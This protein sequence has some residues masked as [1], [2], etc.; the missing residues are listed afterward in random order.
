M[1]ANAVILRQDWLFRVRPL[2]DG[3]GSATTQACG[4][5]S[6][7]SY[8]SILERLD[9]C[10]AV[11]RPCFAAEHHRFSLLQS[12]DDQS[13]RLLRELG[14]AWGMPNTV[15]CCMQKGE[16][17]GRGVV[18]YL[19]NSRTSSFILSTSSLVRG[20]ISSLGGERS[21]FPIGSTMVSPSS[22][23]SK[24]MLEFLGRIQLAHWF[25]RRRSPLPSSSLARAAENTSPSLVVFSWVSLMVFTRLNPPFCS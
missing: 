22:S 15:L 23:S 10:R 6:N 17:G 16:R 11:P 13:M 12:M 25:T 5:G 7:T 9:G 8:L 24:L 21:R 19:R 18:R 20:P 2:Q 3:G 1:D 4:E 14:G